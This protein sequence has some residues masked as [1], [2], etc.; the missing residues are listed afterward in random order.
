MDMKKKITAVLL[1]IIT[2]F[3]SK[4]DAQ[5]YVSVDGSDEN[6]GTREQPFKT[7]QKAAGVMSAGD[8]CYVMSGIYRETVIPANDGTAGSPLV[9]T[10]YGEGK[11]Y[12]TGSDTVSGWEVWKDNIY[13]ACFPDSV[14]QLFVNKKRAYPARYPDFITG[15][16]HSTA[17]WRQ[18][19]ASADGDADFSGIDFPQDYWKGGYCRIL[20][21][22]KWIAHIGKISSSGSSVVHCNE[23]SSPWNDYNPGV[24]LGKGVGY[25][26]HHIHALDSPNEWH[27]QN[28]TLYYYPEPGTDMTKAHVE[29]R[30][31]YLGFN[32]SGRSYIEIKNINFAWAS[33]S[34]ENATGCLLEGASVIFTDPFFYYTSGWSNTTGGVVVS[35]S[36]NVIKDC[37]VAHTWG[38]GISI[39]GTNNTVENC[40]VEDCDW[41]AT[42]ASAVFVKGEDHQ[43]LH[44]TLRKT[45]RSILVH[46]RSKKTDIMY[47]DMYDCGLLCDDLGLTYAYMSNGDGSNIAYNFVH[48]NH[49]VGTSS[50]IYLDNYDT[51]FIVHHNVVWNCGIGIQ[52]NKPGVDHEIYNNTVWNCQ[53]AQHAWGQDGTEIVNQKVK[54]N[55]SDKPWYVGTEF[56]NNLQT[57]DPGFMDA[58]NHDF[59]LK[60]GSPAIDYGVVIDG[61]TDGY[62]GQA[63]DAGAYEFGGEAWTAGSNINIPDL[64]DIYVPDLGSQ[65]FIAYYPFNRNARDESGHGFD[66]TEVNAWMTQDRHNNP[67]SAFLF[68]G[69]SKYIFIDSIGFDM[70]KDFTILF[71]IMPMN[72]EGEQWLFGNRYD[73]EGNDKEAF[74][75]MISNGKVHAVIPGVLDLSEKIAVNLWQMVVLT[76]SG[77]NYR[78]Y[79][80]GQFSQ[81]TSSADLLPNNACWSIAARKNGSGWQD[82]YQGSV[83]DIM[84]FGKVLSDDEIRNLY[85]MVTGVKK[86]NDLENNIKVFP[87]PGT[88]RFRIAMNGSGVPVVEVFNSQGDLVVNRTE[89][90]EVNLEGHPSG[91]YIFKISD[92]NGN[93][94]SVNKVVKR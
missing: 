72:T 28:D 33:V 32:A 23:R 54:N 26:T 40:L 75:S 89:T 67:L 5:Y 30:T 27:W 8:T 15:K 45:A 66:A 36:G 60:A 38:S 52:T 22:H 6:P 13:K 83:D 87:N 16:M 73:D 25:I 70:T 3:S 77:N 69:T 42:D 82:F 79:L 93:V 44:N 71:W 59:R 92:K 7:I 80:N 12:I 19:D 46:R 65:Y 35:G 37:Y 53:V 18:V 78:F 76:K 84:I 56:E 90:G 88:S 63:P 21:G 48:D 51:G 29:A 24:Y 9:F 1:V 74:E 10:T 62:A 50:G 61:I 43:I 64:S 58:E 68:D 34:F 55:L 11:V 86:L 91:L 4:T 20:T 94:L 39:D 49:A 14:T 2:F 17:D 81:E 85:D 41:S 31:R 57:D 47:N